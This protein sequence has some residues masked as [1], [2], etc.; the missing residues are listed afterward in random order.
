MGLEIIT[1]AETNEIW[2][3]GKEEVKEK[4]AS[5]EITLPF[6][7]SPPI[8]DGGTAGTAEMI[9]ETINPK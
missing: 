6:A 4:I 1:H 3:K 2:E 7:G 8:V 9:A 5:R